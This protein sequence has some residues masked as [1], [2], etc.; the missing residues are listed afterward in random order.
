[1]NRER[2]VKKGREEEKIMKLVFGGRKTKYLIIT[3]P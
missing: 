3:N 1:M 2:A